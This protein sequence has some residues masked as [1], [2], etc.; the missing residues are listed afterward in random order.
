MLLAAS[1]INQNASFSYFFGFLIVYAAGIKLFVIHQNV[2]KL[3]SQLIQVTGSGK[4]G[5]TS[6][7]DEKGMNIHNTDT[8]LK[9]VFPYDNITKIVGTKSYYALFTGQ[10]QFAI[11]NRPELDEAGCRE[12]F[13]EFL[14]NKCPNITWKI[15][16]RERDL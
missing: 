3:T 12:E 2:R 7:F 9:A 4:C 1:L 15:K 8:N 16:N 5:Y 11:V 13:F 10:N 6:S 14:K